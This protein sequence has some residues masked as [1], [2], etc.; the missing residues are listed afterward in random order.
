MTSRR[1]SLRS[2]IPTKSYKE[3]DSDDEN[4]KFKSILGYESGSDFEDDLKKRGA[5]NEEDE[6]DSDE[7][8]LIIDEDL[9]GDANDGYEIMTFLP[10]QSKN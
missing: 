3:I 4:E 8:K 5:E 9:G 10:F 7:D 1:K 6:S 2:S